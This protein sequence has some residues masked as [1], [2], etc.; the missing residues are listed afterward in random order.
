MI[1]KITL[2]ASNNKITKLQVSI[3]VC[4]LTFTATVFGLSI[5][6]RLVDFDGANKLNSIEYLEFSEHISSYIKTGLNGEKGNIIHFT[7]EDCHC[8]R[9]SKQHIEDINQLANKHS[10]N[11]EYISLREHDVIPAT[12]ST[13]IVDNSGKVIYFGPYG[14]GLECNKTE[15]YAQTMINNYL[16]GFSANIVVKEARG[17]YCTT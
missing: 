4:W 16:K 3:I 11:V 13:A 9:Y 15:G 2:R 1:W 6:S 5:N 12:P 7:S 10:F 14:E 17:C 8:N